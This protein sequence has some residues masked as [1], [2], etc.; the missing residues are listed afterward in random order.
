M[1]ESNGTAVKFAADI[2][3]RFAIAQHDARASVA[4]AT[5]TNAREFVAVSRRSARSPAR[6]WLPVAI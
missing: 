1:V 3:G 2:L 4:S 6:A 5:A